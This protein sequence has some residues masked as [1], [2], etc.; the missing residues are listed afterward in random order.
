[1]SFLD[2][3]NLYERNQFLKNQIHK[4]S[5]YPYFA[6]FQTV[7]TLNEYYS[8]YECILG[9]S[10]HIKKLNLIDFDKKKWLLGGF[11]Y[12]FKSKIEPSCPNFLDSTIPFPDIA[13][14]EP[15]IIF[16]VK[17][18]EPLKVYYEGNFKD[19]SY[20]E[21]ERAS[22]NYG[23]LQSTIS[24][25]E[26]Q[27]KLNKIFEYLKRGDIYEVNFTVE[28]LIK[29]LKIHPINF[30]ERLIKNSPTPQAGILKWKN[31]W[32]ICASQ[33][34][35]L[36]KKNDIL[37]SQPIKGTIKRAF[38]YDYQKVLELFY[39]KKNRSE[40]VMIVDLVRNDMNRVCEPRSVQVERLYQ[41]QTYEF[42][43]QMV[44]TIKGKVK[45]NISNFEIIKSLFPAGSMTGC[46]KIRAMQIIEELEKKGRGIYSGSIGYFHEGNFDLNVVIR[47]L[48]WNENK[49][50][51]SFHVGGAITLHSDWESEY[52]ECQIKAQAIMKTLGFLNKK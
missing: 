3:K 5:E 49:K 51:G 18:Q 27:Q 29:D 26:Y 14:F 34:R 42:L 11:S 16:Y 20:E 52:K 39:S 44:S 31:Q 1:M 13:F 33:E 25:I 17:T 35:F 41:I 21:L 30:Y 28:Y 47:S 10:K 36:K 45:N 40:N 46:P 32:L 48:V 15:E 12:S 7:N 4:L 8:D 2:F 6:L 22:L 37:I 38:I 43:H 9:A 50:L 23:N 19:N 24:E